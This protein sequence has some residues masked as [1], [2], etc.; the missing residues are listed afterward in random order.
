MEK[1]RGRDYKGQK[2]N[3]RGDEAYVH[4][5]DVVMV[6]GYVCVSKLNKLY[7]LNIRSLCMSIIL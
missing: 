7:T 2:K 1:W 5:L 6:H 4:F 3:F